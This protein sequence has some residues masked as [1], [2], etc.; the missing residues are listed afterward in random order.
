[1]EEPV[2]KGPILN[3]HMAKTTSEKLGARDGSALLLIGPPK[4]WRLDPLPAGATAAVAAC[5]ADAAGSTADLTVLFVPDAATLEMSLGDALKTVPLDG[6]FWVAYRKGGAKAG[7][8]LNRD[9]LQARLAGHGV[10]GVT[11]VSL[12]ETWSALRV[13]PTTHVGRR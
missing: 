3:L 2:R 7:T 6:L 5:A 12:D 10:T 9:L 13:R 1:M 8:D 11:L 4:D